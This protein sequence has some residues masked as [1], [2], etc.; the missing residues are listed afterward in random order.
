MYTS[1]SMTTY[2]SNYQYNLKILTRDVV[3]CG[4]DGVRIVDCCAVEVFFVLLLSVYVF[5]VVLISLLALPIAL[6]TSLYAC[7]ACPYSSM[8]FHQP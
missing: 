7:L 4:G 6:R 8:D 5:S 1:T 2:L 3:L